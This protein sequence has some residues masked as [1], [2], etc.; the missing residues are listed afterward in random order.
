MGKNRKEKAFDL[1]A[2][3]IGLLHLLVGVLLV[4]ISFGLG[5]SHTDQET[6][7]MFVPSFSE[8]LLGHHDDLGLYFPTLAFFS[9]FPAVVLGLIN[10]RLG[11]Y[12]LTALAVIGVWVSF[13]HTNIGE[14]EAIPIFI[15]YPITLALIAIGFEKRYKNDTRTF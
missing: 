3:I 14:L 15:G 10:P 7:G 9:T 5:P 6:L 4:M 12:A 11:S 2:V 8:R 13:S 1:F